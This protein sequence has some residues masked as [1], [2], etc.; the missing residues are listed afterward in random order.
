MASCGGGEQEKKDWR[1]RRRNERLA[2]SHW[3]LDLLLLLRQYYGAF[4]QVSASAFHLFE[5][6]RHRVRRDDLSIF[7]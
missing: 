1:R 5:P 4:Q 6:Q 3:L 7:M 2:V